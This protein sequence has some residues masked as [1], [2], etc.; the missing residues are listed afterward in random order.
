MY[1]HEA[2]VTKKHASCLASI[3][4]TSEKNKMKKRKKNIPR[5]RTK[6]DPPEPMVVQRDEERRGGMMMRK[7]LSS[8]GNVDFDDDDQQ[9]EEM[10]VEDDD[11]EEEEEEEEDKEAE[12]EDTRNNEYNNNVVAS[13]SSCYFKAKNININRMLKACKPNNA[14]APEFLGNLSHLLRPTLRPYQKRAVGW[15]MGRE[16]APN[17]P[18][19]WENG[20]N[21]H[22]DVEKLVTFKREEQLS[23]LREM[24]KTTTT[25]TAKMT[26]IEANVVKKKHEEI[27]LW[28]ENVSKSMAMEDDGVRGGV[29]AE[30]MGLG[31]TVELLMLCLA[32]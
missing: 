28:M 1:I 20:K 7:M 9:E 12:E 3:M 26:L 32:H 29:L 14:N 25:T 15:M 24:F 19:G 30:E 10:F 18:V 6:E 16:R 31:K 4:T 5:K 2:N 11:D 17:A 23:A 21:Q 22:A 8:R 27:N 13:S